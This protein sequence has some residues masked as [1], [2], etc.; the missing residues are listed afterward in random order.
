VKPEIKAYID[1]KLLFFSFINGNDIRKEFD[2][3]DLIYI[4]D[5]FEEYQTFNKFVSRSCLPIEE[6]KK[7]TG[8][9]YFDIFLKSKK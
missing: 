6:K 4:D 2:I 8:M 5:I 9:S 7:I 1:Y 3:N